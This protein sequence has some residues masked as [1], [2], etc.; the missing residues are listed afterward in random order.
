M[1]TQQERVALSLATPNEVINSSIIGLFDGALNRY[2]VDVSRFPVVFVTT[3]VAQFPPI[4]AALC[5]WC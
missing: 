2:V 3:L 5:C 4:V 1:K